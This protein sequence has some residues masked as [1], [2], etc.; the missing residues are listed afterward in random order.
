MAPPAPL[1]SPPP[2]EFEMRRA[3]STAAASLPKFPST[4]SVLKQAVLGFGLAFGGDV[5]AQSVE[6]R[7]AKKHD[8]GTSAPGSAVRVGAYEDWNAK[9][10]LAISTFGAFWTGPYNA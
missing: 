4:K 9:R 10:T 7:L 3:L 5:L 6:K 2:R 8:G 1:P